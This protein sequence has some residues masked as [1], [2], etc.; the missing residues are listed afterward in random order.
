MTARRG[1]LVALIAY[2]VVLSACGDKAY[3]PL[4]SANLVAAI[5]AASKNLHTAHEVTTGSGV[6]TTI[7]FDTSGTFTYRLTQAAA[8]AST[9]TETLIGIGGSRYLQAAGVTPVGKWVKLSATD[10]AEILTFKAIDPVA[11]VARFSKGQKTFRYAGAGK[12]DGAEVQHYRIVID[13]QKYLQATGQ[14]LGSANLGSGEALTEDLYLNDDNTVRRVMVSLPGGVG[15]TRV[16]ITR[17]GSPVQIQ[18]PAASTVIASTT[19]K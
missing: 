14:G 5:T 7:D 12:I 15:D 19:K 17:W 8:S 6:I 10:T 9:S 2:T 16:D 3:V 1:A 11:M 13:Q 4:T 18:A